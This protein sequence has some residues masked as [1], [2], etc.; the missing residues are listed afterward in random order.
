MSSTPVLNAAHVYQIGA[1][2]QVIAPHFQV[3][4]AL[5]AAHAQ[6]GRGVVERRGL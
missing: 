5:L 3:A 4:D 2:R 1:S 6:P